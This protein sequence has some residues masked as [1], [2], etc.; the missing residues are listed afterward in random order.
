MPTPTLFPM[1]VVCRR[2]GLS[3]HV[4]RAWES[5]YEAVV[6]VRTPSNR[7]MYR[8]E[9]L[10]RLSWLAHL[11]QGGYSIGQ[12]AQLP[13]KELQ[14]LGGDSTPAPPAE[15]VP[16]GRSG[17][18]RVTPATV[19]EACLGCVRALDAAG[20]EAELRRAAVT[21]SYPKLLQDVLAPLL[22]RIGDLWQTGDLRI[23][24]E[25]LASVVVR[26]FLL[27]VPASHGLPASAPRLVL[28]TPSGCQHEFGALLAA[29]TAASKGWQV[30]YLGPNLPAAEV[31]AA[32]LAVRAKAL[33]LSVIYPAD[34]VQLPAE[35]RRLRQ[36]L[37]E[38]PVVVGGRA[39]P[40]YAAELTAAGMTWI[41]DLGAF[42]RWLDAV[43]DG[44]GRTAGLYH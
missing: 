40:R 12:I 3:A 42:P 31:A 36:L 11:T 35:L 20:L 1:K 14:A 33:A 9:D 37:P 39:A 8:S 26:E 19:I 5:R 13:L 25:H 43:L 28:T 7:R 38:L 41:S 2:T 6:P 18:E 10:E 30:T 27:A 4:L 21:F 44:S 22:A 23:L 34:D 32:V 24:H 15:R 17:L 29:G 16:R